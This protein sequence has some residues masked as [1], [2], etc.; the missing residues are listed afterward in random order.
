MQHVRQAVPES[1]RWGTRGDS[2]GFFVFPLLAPGGLPAF[3]SR[4]KSSPLHGPFPFEQQVRCTDERPRGPFRSRL[5]IRR[6]VGEVG[7]KFIRR[8]DAAEKLS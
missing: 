5:R 7:H 1:R 2:K 6:H 3:E 4:A 8:F